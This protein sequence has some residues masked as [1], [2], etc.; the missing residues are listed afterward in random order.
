MY[1]VTQTLENGEITM[2]DN[3]TITNTNDRQNGDTTISI[4]EIVDGNTYYQSV[5]YFDDGYAITHTTAIN[6]VVIS[7]GPGYPET[8]PL[9]RTGIE[10]ARYW[11]RNITTRI[12]H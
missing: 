5:R 11:K 9:T 3:T 2:G 10:D 8:G 6:G 1:T 7:S 12:Y 4:E